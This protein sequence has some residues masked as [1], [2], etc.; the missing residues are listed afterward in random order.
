ML[1]EPTNTF[2]AGLFLEQRDRGSGITMFCRRSQQSIVLPTRFLKSSRCKHLQ[3]LYTWGK[4]DDLQPD[5]SE[6]IPSLDT[7]QRRVDQVSRCWVG[8]EHSF[9]SPSANSDFKLELTIHDWGKIT[10]IG[11]QDGLPAS[12]RAEEVWG[13]RR[14]WRSFRWIWIGRDGRHG[15]GVG[16]PRWLD[17][18]ESLRPSSILKRASFH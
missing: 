4:W 14:K 2:L 8:R 12:M 7:R 9:R 16:G 13:R 5:T 3:W 11:L 1:L 10:G 15:W 17:W 18:Q 6:R